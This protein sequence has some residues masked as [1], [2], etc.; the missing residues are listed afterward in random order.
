MPLPTNPVDKVLYKARKN[1]G[2]GENH[3]TINELGIEWYNQVQRDVC[4][5]GNYWFMRATKTFTFAIGDGQET[6]PSVSGGD[7]F[8]FKDEDLVYIVDSNG[9]FTELRAMDDEDY[10]RMF[11]DTTQGTPTHYRI[12]SD[13]LV[14]RPLPNI[15]T[16]IKMDYWGY[17]ANLVESN[18]NTNTLLDRFPRLLEEGVTAYGFDYLEEEEKSQIWV[19][20][21]QNSLMELKMYNAER[22]LPN[23]I[24]IRPR[25]GARGSQ[26]RRIKSW[27]VY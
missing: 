13:N 14:I 1:L 10:V 21:T 9:K 16:T 26:F 11:D 2:R 22:I 5:S 8:D 4:N 24:V 23:E 17:L 19:Q 3:S 7:S 6:L 12:D 27:R 20:K 25:Q 15:S 18:A